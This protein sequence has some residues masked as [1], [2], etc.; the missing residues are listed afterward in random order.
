MLFS[1]TLESRVHLRN[2]LLVV[3]SGPIAIHFGDCAID[4]EPKI[5]FDL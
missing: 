4:A 2:A 5:V 1:E 3:D